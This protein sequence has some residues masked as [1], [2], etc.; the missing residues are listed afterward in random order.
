MTKETSDMI[1]GAG[2]SK[3]ESGILLSV[4]T[5]AKMNAGMLSRI[6]K[7]TPHDI[8][9]A[10]SVIR[11]IC[12][13]TDEVFELLLVGSLHVQYAQTNNSSLEDVI[14][15]L[16]DPAFDDARQVL[17]H[18]ANAQHYQK[19]THP[20]IKK[21]A[22]SLLEKDESG[23]IVFQNIFDNAKEVITNYLEK[24]KVPAPFK[25]GKARQTDVPVAPFTQDIEVFFESSIKTMRETTEVLDRD[26]KHHG[27]SMCKR[28]EVG[29]KGFRSI[30]QIT[31]ESISSLFAEFENML[32]PLS[33]LTNELTLNANISPQDFF[34]TPMLFLGEAGIGKTALANSLSRAL[35]VPFKKCK[36]SEPS[37]YLTGSHQTWRQAAP[38]QV[39]KQ[40]IS[41]DCASPL[42]FVDE[43]EKKGSQQYP[44]SNALLDLLEPESARNFKDEFFDATFNASHA[45]WILAANTTDDLPDSLLSRLS[46]FE[47]PTPGF[48]QRLR[49]IL[50]DFKN[51]NQKTNR[52]IGIRANDADRLAERTDLDLRQIS[53]VV[54]DSFIVALRDDVKTAKF[55]MPKY[56]GKRI[57][58]ISK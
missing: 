23:A 16:F 24:Q 30:P 11:E 51:L 49:I 7:F 34:I 20:A 46:I 42:F 55:E 48:E 37:F 18:M 17:V 21:I 36:G 13:R 35:G 10:Q 57:G 27:T 2:Y 33:Q 14:S 4:S 6:R 58:F 32:G 41:H 40:L 53:R 56:N 31:S 50:Q 54:R 12:N 8:E 3:T 5:L 44:I 25:E 1:F 28:L 45:I 47:I 29:K 19:T 9:D 52:E 15:Y 26:V 22:E 43:L 39:I 38:G